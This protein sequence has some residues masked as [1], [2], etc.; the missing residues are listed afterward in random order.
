MSATHDTFIFDL[1]GTLL[2]TLPDLVVNTNTALTQLGYPA[3][4]EEDIH[5]AIGDGLMPLMRR[6]L[7]PSAGDEQVERAFERWKALY[8]ECG[9]KF[10]K[11]YPGITSLLK[12]LS[13][14]NIKLAVLSN[15][16]DY[17]VKDLINDHFPGLFIVAYGEGPG[18]P[19]KPDPQGLLTVIEELGSLPKNSVY[20][21]DSPTDV[22]TAHRAGAFSV[23]VSWGYHDL[24]EL[25]TAGA[26][27]V[28]TRPEEIMAYI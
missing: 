5:G 18:I 23:G 27:A 13:G 10:A 21:G 22:Q 9:T 8:P 6:M 26:D 15:K 2:D 28:V 24:D 3:R 12:Q 25:T 1:D 17:G 19:R 20:V 14:R 11:E 7:P 16:F 4:S